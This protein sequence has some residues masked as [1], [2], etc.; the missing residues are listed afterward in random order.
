MTVTTPINFLFCSE[1]G[2]LRPGWR[3]VIAAV[4]FVFAEYAC[5]YVVLSFGGGAKGV[6][7]FEALYRPLLLIFLLA[8]FSVMVRVFDC[9]LKNPIS[10]Q[11]LG[12]SGLWIRDQLLGLALGVGMIAVAIIAIFLIGAYSLHS[13][14]PPA[15]QILVV[16]WI[17]L[18]SAAAEEVAFRGYPFQR[19]IEGVGQGRAVFLMSALFGALHLNNP[20]VSLWGLFNTM[21]VG[22]LLSVAYLRTRTLWLPIGIH[23]GWNTALGFIFGLPV[24]GLKI[25]SVA[26]E[27]SAWGP[28]WLTGGDYGIEASLT[29]AVV[30]SAGIVALLMKP[31]QKES[32]IETSSASERSGIQLS[33]SPKF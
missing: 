11:G 19:L 6:Y 16:L 10:A 29:G 20:H 17:L 31:P 9:N 33:D 3:F 23:L 28:I 14:K 12:F 22:V 4:F 26:V 5:A 8:G 21:L 18:I 1:D 2:R 25:F 15:G 13:L 32:L 27:G 24:S 7:L 30:V